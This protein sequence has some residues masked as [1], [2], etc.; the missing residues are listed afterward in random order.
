MPV[1]VDDAPPP[2]AGGAS[3]PQQSGIQIEPDSLVAGQAV[4]G[5]RGWCWEARSSGT[6]ATWSA[7]ARK[8]TGRA[9]PPSSA[10]IRQERRHGCLEA[11]R[12]A[13]CVPHGGK[14]NIVALAAGG[15]S[16]RGGLP[17]QGEAGQIMVQQRAGHLLDRMAADGFQFLAQAEN[18]D[19]VNAAPQRAGGQDAV[20]RRSLGT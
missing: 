8:R 13:W 14:T 4:G 18:A 19:T 5:E 6:A 10:D 20:V 7:D 3:H 1:T 2:L 16:R 11:E 9:M 15:A 17:R 12:F